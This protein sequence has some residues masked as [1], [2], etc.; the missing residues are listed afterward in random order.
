MNVTALFDEIK[1]DLTQ[2]EQH[3]LSHLNTEIPL[4]N[5]VGQYILEAGGKRLRPALMLFSSRMFDQPDERIYTAASALEYLHTATLLHDDVVDEADTRR[6]KKAARMIWGNQ[7]SVLVGDYLLATAFRNLTLL[8]NQEVLETVSEVTSMMAKGEI[9]QLIRRFDSA[10]EQDYM[11][12]IINKTACLF[13]AA[14]KIGAVY[15]G[16]SDEHARALYEYGMAM[17]IAF[18]IVDDALD[19]AENRDKVGKPLGIDLKERKVTLPLSRLLQV[20]DEPE[21]RR[22]GEILKKEEI[23]DADVLEVMGMMKTHEVIAYTLAEARR[24]TERGKAHLDALPDRPVK[25]T[26]KRLADFVVDRDF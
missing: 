9:L 11:D 25:T 13:A 7:A 8:K 3:I 5:E 4:L 1:D 21:K 14:S 20:A 10:T 15:H 22:L 6:A 2:V 26:L 24:H 19:Y 12:I 23:T 16:A 17:G 18:Q